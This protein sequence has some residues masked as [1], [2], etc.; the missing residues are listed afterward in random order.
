[1]PITEEN[2]REIERVIA[3]TVLCKRDLACYNSNFQDVAKGTVIN[4]GQA[5]EC[6]EKGAKTCNYSIPFG[7]SYFCNCPMRQYIAQK[8]NK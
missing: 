1:M 8:L 6:L 4:G 5:V 3:E 2:R 7:L